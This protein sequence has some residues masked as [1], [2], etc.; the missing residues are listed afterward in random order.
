MHEY[1]ILNPSIIS[2]SL[3][4]EDNSETTAHNL[5]IEMD[6]LEGD[7][8]VERARWIKAWPPLCFDIH[9]FLFASCV[10]PLENSLHRSTDSNSTTGLIID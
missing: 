3:Q 2:L 10:S 7:E 9:C 6:E 4:G 1:Y 5:F 8:W